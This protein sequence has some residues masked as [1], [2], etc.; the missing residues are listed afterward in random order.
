M[1]FVGLFLLAASPRVA[2]RQKVVLT[3]AQLQMLAAAYA[4]FKAS[5]YAE[6]DYPES[7]TKV[8]D[9]GATMEPVDGGTLIRFAVDATYTGPFFEGG[10]VRYEF[11][12]DGG[13]K[14]RVFEK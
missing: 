1:T 10:T 3:N 7:P 2:T 8:T 6:M 11:G 9:Y 12:V 4:D 13:L 14:R 5:A